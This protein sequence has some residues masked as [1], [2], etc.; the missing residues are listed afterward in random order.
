MKNYELSSLISSQLSEENIKSFSEKI[1]ALIKSEG[2]ESINA[3]NPSRRR[4]GY[5][6]KKER[7]AWFSVISF[8][9]QPEK[10]EYLK[11]GLK[12]LPE[13]L[14]FMILN[15]KPVSE[16]AIN[17]ILENKEPKAETT[18]KNLGQTPEIKEPKEEKVELEEIDK[19]L[20]EILGEN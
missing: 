10:I 5:A 16:L 14:R 6:I 3:K 9:L 17:K 8:D 13:I 2:A 12:A 11:T 20:E 1:S 19:K 15:Q 7:Q 4:I 18:E